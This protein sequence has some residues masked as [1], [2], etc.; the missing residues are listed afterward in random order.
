[1]EGPVRS[2]PGSVTAMQY[3]DEALPQ[4]GAKTAHFCSMCGSNFCSMEI[5]HQIR[6]LEDQDEIKTE[7]MAEMS[8]KFKEYG[9]ELYI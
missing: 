8:A 6:S 4:E 2:Q 3:H 1:M 7:G 9:K 5:T